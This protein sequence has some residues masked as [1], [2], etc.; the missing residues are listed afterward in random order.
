MALFEIS[1]AEWSLH[2]SLFTRRL[3]HID[4]PRIAKE[5]YGIDAI[6]L[7]NRFF[8]GKARDKKHL[9]EFKT[10]A[11]DMGARILLIMCDDEGDLGDPVEARRKRA[12]ENHHQW[13]EA[14]KF[15]GCHSIRVNARSSGSYA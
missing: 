5:D 7:V 8:K 15:F 2:R 1:L 9:T 12:V 4:F 3:R 13:L 14:A 10:R 6:E 11:D